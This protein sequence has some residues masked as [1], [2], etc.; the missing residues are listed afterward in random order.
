MDPLA[1]GLVPERTDDPVVA[2]DLVARHGIAILTGRGT[3]EAGAQGVATDVLG[4]LLALP[5]ACAV[6]EGGEGD[7]VAVGS[8]QML[9]VHA[10]GFAYGDQHPDGL[11]L[12]CVHQGTGGGE[13]IALD[14]YALLDALAH[15]DPEL[16]HFLLHVPVDLT[17]PDMRPTI[18]PIVLTLASGRLAVRRSLYMAPAPDADDVDLDAA[19]ILRW[20]T[21]A[22]SLSEGLP[23]FRLDRGEALCIDNYRVLH[24]RDPFAGERF[25]WRIWAWTPRS[26][27]VPSGPLHSDS[28][29]ASA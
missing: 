20:R 28:R 23:R 21:L 13:S 29:Y 15:E 1:V 25:L 4:D 6:R 16:H 11:F 17:E 24:G 27:G 14:A 5:D 19:R 8:D 7:R 18:S 2:A 9:P 12:L 10:D 26:N 3:D 22:R